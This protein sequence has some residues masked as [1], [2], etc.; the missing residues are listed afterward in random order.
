M[1]PYPFKTRIT[2]K[3]VKNSR[4]RISPDCTVHVTAP[5]GADAKALIDSRKDWI[6]KKIRE[7]NHLA[8]VYE[9]SDG[10]FMYNGKMWHPVFSESAP[11]SFSWPDIYYPSVK[12]L[13]KSIT[14]S[15][16]KDISERLDY[17]SEMM[18]VDYGKVAV[19]NQR[20][21][22]GS[23]SGKGNLNFNIRAMA[24]PETVRN[25]LVIHELAHR[26]EMNHSPSFW[27]NVSRYYPGYREAEKELKA[28]WIVVGRCRIWN[29]L[30]DY[31][32][33]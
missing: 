6:Q 24:L 27:N 15:L 12:E 20:T 18:G 29:A 8:S 2:H 22:W 11:V 19:R 16:R 17:Y 21:R 14:K 32:G 4:I 9:T 7:L 30:L 33:H 23:C 25:Y 13:K 1:E 26:T 5:H 3:D 28:C 31:R 10:S